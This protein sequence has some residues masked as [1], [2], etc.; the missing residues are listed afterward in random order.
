MNTGGLTPAG[1]RK[2]SFQ[3]ERYGCSGYCGRFWRGS[4]PLLLE[5][6]ELS[7][8]PAVVRYIPQMF[9][10]IVRRSGRQIFVST[11]SEDML[12][13]TGIAPSEIVL[14]KPTKDGT[15]AHLAEE[16]LDIKALA[17][18]GEPLSE[19]V[20]PRTAAPQASQLALFGEAH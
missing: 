14:L 16:D 6:P 18:A 3:M 10:R 2:T 11:H 4:G 17:E 19:A 15:E 5:E 9:A 7:L 12:S 8:H 13:D 20:I 1:N